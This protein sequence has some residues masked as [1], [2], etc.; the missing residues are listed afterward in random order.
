MRGAHLSLI[1]EFVGRGDL[2]MGGAYAEPVDGA[3]IVF[4][5]KNAAEQFV[6]KDPYVE[7]GL[8]QRWHVRE[9][10]TVEM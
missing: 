1:S 10:H 7:G 8:V 6:E 5:D 4:A 3:A 9:W 2:I